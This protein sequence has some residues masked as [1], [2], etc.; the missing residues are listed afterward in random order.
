MT[1]NF[2]FAIA[3]WRKNEVFLGCGL[4]PPTSSK[5]PTRIALGTLDLHF[6]QY[7]LEKFRGML[8][9]AFEL[10]EEAYG[11]WRWRTIYTLM[12]CES[13]FCVNFI[14]REPGKGQI[15]HAMRGKNKE[16]AQSLQVYCHDLN[17]IR[18]ILPVN[19][20]TEASDLSVKNITETV[21]QFEST[22]R[23]VIEKALTC[24]INDPQAKGIALTLDREPDK[25]E[26][27]I[28]IKA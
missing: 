18:F 3:H 1:V 6:E 25:P 7:T 27:Y 10:S 23:S 22:V 17:T 11:V 9:A 5:K 15:V 2:C 19:Q 14:P 28:W 24:F 26:T 8:E 16:E 12:Q 21:V 20:W 4:D 13:I